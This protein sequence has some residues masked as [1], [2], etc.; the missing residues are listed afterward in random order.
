VDP[1]QME[2]VVLN[3]AVN[4]RDAMPGGGELT[5][6]TANV[7]LDTAFARRHPF[8]LPGPY[9]CLSVRDT[10]TGM[11]RETLEQAFEPFFT[12]KPPG[13]GTGLGL[14]TV[15]GIV[16]QSEGYVFLESEPGTGTV[17]SVYLPRA[18][19]P[20]DEPAG[21]GDGGGALRKGAGTVLLVE[22]EVAVRNL[23]KR[24]LQRGGYQVL[25][26]HDGYQALRVASAHDGPIDLLLSD[27]VMPR[28]GGRELA[29][30]LRDA[31][32]GVR[33]LFVSGYAGV[34][35]ARDAVPLAGEEVLEKP[36]S[37]E[38]LARAVHDALSRPAPG[39]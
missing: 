31:R 28:M 6:E 38:S 3:L 18:Q 15:Y 5:I 9:V 1:G 23:A 20:D 17:V 37:P 22:D 19:A 4:A 26:A 27:V 16:K 7:E 12:T 11:D 34:E 2:Q 8:V 29:R 14:S 25:E 13:R 24:V 10:G 36:Y 32:P 33:V 30:R 21:G 39:S 35:P